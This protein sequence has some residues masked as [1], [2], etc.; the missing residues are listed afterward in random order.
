MLFQFEYNSKRLILSSMEM[1]F[2]KSININLKHEN[3]N[4]NCFKQ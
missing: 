1:N 4:D 2:E 3:K